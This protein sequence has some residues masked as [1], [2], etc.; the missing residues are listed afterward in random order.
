MFL[1]VWA[2]GEYLW[3]M[4]INFVEKVGLEMVVNFRVRA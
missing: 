3:I 2:G 1:F 4:K